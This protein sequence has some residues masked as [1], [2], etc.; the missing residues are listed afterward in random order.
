[1]SNASGVF[2]ELR[3]RKVIQTAIV[4]IA[5]AWAGIEVVTTL[6]P[7][8]GGGDTAVRLA[9]GLILLG[10]P[11][12]IAIS[13]LFDFTPSGFT[14]DTGPPVVADAT[15]EKTPARQPVLGRMPPAPAT[16][17]VGRADDVAAVTA[18]VKNDARMV[19]ITGP[20]GT[21]K[22][23]LAIAAA[24]ALVDAFPDGLA[25]VEL[26][27]VTDPAEVVPM[28]ARSI[29]VKE[30]ETRSLAHGLTTII[31]D[32]SVLLVLDNLEQVIGAAPDLAA[33]LG[34]C[35][36]LRMLCTSRAPL[37]LSAEL[38]YPLRP[39]VLPPAGEMPP[40]QDLERYP[41]VE[42]FLDRTRRA[43][44][45][46]RL[47]SDNADAVLRICRRLDGLPLALELAAARLR[48][49]EP[50]ALLQRLEHALDVLTAG[51][52]DL[53]ERQRT[54]RATIDWSHSLLDSE[55]Q[56]LFRR[57]AV[58]AGGWTHDAVTR[59]CFD[60]AEDSPL[61]A[62]ESLVEKGLVR[63]TDSPGRFAMLE[64]IREY[65]MER[66]AE[67]EEVE[68]LRRRHATHYVA[69][70][71]E[72]HRESRGNG[73]LE[74]MR[75]NDAES[76]NTAEALAWLYDAGAAG[77]RE[78]VDLGLRLCGELWMYW[79]VRGLHIKAHEWSRR[80]LDLAD[81]GA[82]P[83][84]RTRALIT[85]AV[86][87]MTLGN[88]AR[89]LEEISEAEAH[90]ANV[91]DGTSATV[92][93]VSGVAQLIAGDPAAARPFLVE[94]VRRGRETEQR[95][96]LGLALSFLGIVETALGNPD[97]AR[98]HFDEGL[99][100][101]R[102][103]DDY[104]GLGSTL[105]GLAALEAAAGRHEAARTLYREAF[106]AY[107]AIGDRPEEA[108][109]LDELAWAALASGSSV[110]AREHFAASLQAYEEVGS[111]RGSGLALLGLAATHAAEDRPERALR[112]AAAAATFCEQ[113]GVAN[114]YARH[115]AAP[116]YIESAR[117]SLDPVVLVRIEA[118][119]RTM[120]VHDAVRAALDPSDEVAAAFT[121]H[122]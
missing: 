49:L 16:P 86:A 58:F 100:I 19:T 104:E 30:A 10:L 105:G 122:G 55:E 22:T 62:F 91:P 79:H 9:V 81:T 101:Q 7:V 72:M 84:A 50:D 32:R 94:A 110:D 53:P 12:A 25:Y 26:A 61:D 14:R 3:R 33:L 112:I 76:A 27:A 67:S 36:S 99:A 93:V 83:R 56:R 11:V 77:D 111:I 92:Q 34:D 114:D 107:H 65:A 45:A 17:L 108:R 51:A 103:I 35:A 121:S 102:A 97:A 82:E 20:G 57:L 78:A 90:G 96:E 88:P 69:L 106:D 48:T 23:R 6:L 115:T 8:Y 4:Y 29:G 95:W 15:P 46:F 39:L 119:G 37:R 68:T 73:Q 43:R 42:L 109:I 59:V 70:A 21:G 44:P 1:M 60:D 98:A 18:R 63:A 24:S 28:I 31:G 13:W 52:R 41:A 113:E 38:E 40:L 80:F 75:R 64:T 71:E 54:L 117:A 118:E 5:L 120:S 2:S 74:S 89:A 87:S 66:L 116:R 47:T 85:A